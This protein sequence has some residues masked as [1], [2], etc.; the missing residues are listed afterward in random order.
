MFHY[1][2]CGNLS[3]PCD[4]IYQWG[5]E[6]CLHLRD[7]N[8]FQGSVHRGVLAKQRLVLLELFSSEWLF[9]GAPRSLSLVAWMCGGI[10][11]NNFCALYSTFVIVSTRCLC[12]P[13]PRFDATDSILLLINR[14][15]SISP[16]IVSYPSIFGRI[17]V[18]NSASTPLTLIF[19]P[20]ISSQTL[21]GINGGL[22]P[23][24]NSSNLLKAI[25]RLTRHH[26]R[27]ELKFD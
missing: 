7:N 3:K 5:K 9:L 11:T 17:G 26:W 4:L 25:Y 16:S 15:R 24:D 22:I 18:R 6:D 27:V 20:A 1:G 2:K 23:W 21:V 10:N 12:R 19:A 13:P 8:I 14:C